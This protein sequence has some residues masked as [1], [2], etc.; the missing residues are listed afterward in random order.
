MIMKEMGAWKSRLHCLSN[1]QWPTASGPFPSKP[2]LVLELICSRSREKCQWKRH[3]G[4]ASKSQT[5]DFTGFSTTSIA[6]PTMRSSATANASQPATNAASGWHSGLPPAPRQ[7]LT[8]R[9]LSQMRLNQ[10]GLNQTGLNQTRINQSSQ[11]PPGTNKGLVPS[12][13]R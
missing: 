7:S 11:L 3:I 6:C 8:T 10:T 2:T 12:Q 5:P 13:Y 4:P 9:I 1:S